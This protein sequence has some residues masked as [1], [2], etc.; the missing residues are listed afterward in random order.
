MLKAGSFNPFL[1]AGQQSDAVKQ[2]IQNSLFNGSIR[3]ASTTLKGIDAVVHVKSS[4][5]Q[6]AMPVLVLVQ[7][8]ANTHT[9]KHLRPL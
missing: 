8:I 7:I 2:S 3:T 1:P 9:N 6:A 4:R 5:Y